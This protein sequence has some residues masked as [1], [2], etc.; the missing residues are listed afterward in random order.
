M[1]QR[2]RVL[3]YMQDF[4]SITS[5]EAYQELGITQLGARIHELKQRGV[6]I[7]TEPVNKVNRYGEPVR[8]VKYMVADNGRAQ[9]VR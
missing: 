5:W 1:I 3:K 4:G 2:E 6:D 8:F 9:D 7:I